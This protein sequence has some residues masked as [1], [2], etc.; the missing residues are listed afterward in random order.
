[1]KPGLAATPKQAAGVRL[2][3]FIA[4]RAAAH[5]HH[6]ALS[7]AAADTS[8][9][10]AT[11]RRPTSS[12]P[13]TPRGW[14]GTW[15]SS[16]I[17]RPVS[18]WAK[19]RPITSPRPRRPSGSRSHIPECRII[20][21][22]R[23]PVD[24]LYSFYRLMRHNGWTRATMEE[25]AESV[26]PAT[27]GSRYAHYLGRWRERFGAE[28]V[29]VALYDDLEQRAAALPGYDLRLHRDSADRA[30]GFAAAGQTGQQRDARPAYRAV[31]RAGLA[32]AAMAPGAQGR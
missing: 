17:A 24:R 15:S 13:T 30:C 32:A 6:L 22:L 7:C 1:M 27:E 3:D 9:C 16:A 19:F 4:D 8:G 23:D 31:R 26:T 11:P 28:R 20:C 21:T 12:R 29:L 5:R 25:L 2:P 10:R 14:S 18:R